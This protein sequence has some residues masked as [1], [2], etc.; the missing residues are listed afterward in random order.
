LIEKL[1]LYVN[2]FPDGRATLTCAHCAVDAQLEGAVPTALHTEHHDDPSPT[3]TTAILWQSPLTP[4]Q[5]IVAARDY[6]MHLKEYG[7]PARA[8]HHRTQD[9]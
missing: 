9:S 8:A 6:C 7:Q 3:G 1:P 5:V 4:E 2:L